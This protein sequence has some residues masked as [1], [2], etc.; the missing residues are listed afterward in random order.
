MS[1]STS[2]PSSVGVF[3]QGAGLLARVVQ[4]ILSIVVAI[5]I[6]GILLVVLEANPANSVVSEVHSWAHWLAGP[7]D[8]MFSFHS[9]NTAVA[10]NWG[11]AAVVYLFVGVVIVRL[12]GGTYR[13]PRGRS[14]IRNQEVL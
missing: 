11:I 14:S 1:S 5:I 6:A 2:D 13:Y 9:A 10:V 8:G 12:L 7:F 4:L 3:G